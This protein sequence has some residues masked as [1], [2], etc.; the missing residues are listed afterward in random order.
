MAFINAFTE[1]AP[2]YVCEN[3]YQI[4]SAFSK[5]YHD[6]HILSEADSDKQFFWIYLCAAT[7]KVLLKHLDVLGIEAV[8]S[9]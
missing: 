6:N 1:R 8:E 4:A 2:N 5:F 3:A 9:M 7:K